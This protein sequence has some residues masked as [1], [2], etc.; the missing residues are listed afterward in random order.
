VLVGSAS[1]FGITS[2][3]ILKRMM[4]LSVPSLTGAG[5]VNV[6]EKWNK[7]PRSAPIVQ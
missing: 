6:T 7:C 3:H 2:L 4:G 1:F 5:Q